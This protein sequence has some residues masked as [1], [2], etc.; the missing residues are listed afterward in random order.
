MPKKIALRIVVAL[1]TIALSLFMLTACEKGKTVAAKGAFIGGTSGVTAEFEP[2]GVEEENIYSIFD[3][4]TFPIGVTVHNK[5]EYELKPG[6]VTVRLLGPSQSEFSGIPSWEL[7]NKET[8]ERISELVPDGGQETLNFASDAK[9]TGKVTGVSERKWSAN[10]EYNYKTYLIIP[11]VC[12]KEDPADERVCT[13][14]EAKTFFVSGAPV[15]VK[16]VSEEVAG[17]GIMALKIK[18][19]NSGTGKVAK[20]GGEFGVRNA[21]VYSIDDAAWECKSGGKVNEAILAEGQAEI[22]CK[23]KEPLAKGT[24]ATKQLQLTFDYKYRSLVEEALRI[25][26]SVK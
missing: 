11:E 23:L 19:S 21:I 24:L 13:L 3:E 10:I 14:K 16:E 12:L 26:E 18:V 2:F 17:K 9:Y 8:I 25:K 5:G 6:D 7:K 4:E 20:P 1:L 22:I 15:T